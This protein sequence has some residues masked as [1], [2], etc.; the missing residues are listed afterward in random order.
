VSDPFTLTPDQVVTVEPVALSL[1]Q[2][3]SVEPITPAPAQ[4]FT[5]QEASKPRGLLQPGNIDLAAQ[6][7]VF[8]DGQVSTVASRSFRDDQGREVLIPTVAADGSRMLSDKEAWEQYRRTGKHLGMFESP[9]TADIYAE[10]L[11]N[12]YAA[13]KYG[14]LQPQPRFTA[15]A[16]GDFVQPDPRSFMVSPGQMTADA[17]ASGLSL[18]PE[19]AQ[20]LAEAIEDARKQEPVEGERVV[21]KTP[22]AG[23]IYGAHQSWIAMRG[24]KN[25]AAGRGENEDYAALAQ[26]IVKRERDAQR[27]AE[28]GTLGRI[29]DLATSVPGYAAEFIATGGAFT[30]GKG[31]VQRAALKLLEKQ[32]EQTAVRVGVKVAGGAAGAALQTAAVGSQRIAQ[33]AVENMAPKLGLTQDEAGRLQLILL[34]EGDGFAEAVGK[35]YW[36][37][38]IQTASERTGGIIGKLLGKIPGA[39]KLTG[40]KAAIVSQW[41]SKP[42]NTVGKLATLASKAQWHGVLPEVGEELVAEAAEV[43]TGLKDEWQIGP[44]QTLEMAAAFSLFP[45]AGA[46]VRATGKALNLM[47]TNPEAAQALAQGAEASRA[48]VPGVESREE[49]EAVADAVKALAEEQASTAQEPAPHAQPQ[50]I[51][52][53]SPP[54]PEAASAQTPSA[55]PAG[56]QVTAP[57]L[58]VAESAPNLS[59]M[60]LPDL[61]KMA[62][63]L[64]VKGYS[65]KTKAAVIGMIEERNRRQPPTQP[66][67]TTDTSPPARPDLANPLVAPEAR[68]LVDRV[69]A[70]RTAAGKPERRADVAVFQAAT[71]RAQADPEGVR[72]QLLNAADQGTVMADVDTVAA[73]QVLDRD[74]LTALQSGD[75]AALQQAIDLNDAYRRTGTEAGRAFRQRRDW[76]ETPE[77]RFARTLADAILTPPQK[78][79]KKIDKARA[80]GNGE[81]VKQAQREWADRVQGL[82]DQLAKDGIDLGDVQGLAQDRVKGMRALRAIQAYKADTW[83][84]LYE[85][86]RNAI[87]SAPTTHAANLIGNFGH[88]TWHFAAERLAEATA[89]TFAQRPTGA[90][91]GEFKYM[92]QGMLP[93]LSQGARNFLLSWKTETPYFEQSLGR[94]GTRKIEESGVAIGGTKGRIV[95]MFGDRLLV[96]SD[97]LAKT[98]FAQMDVGTR[99]YRIA[100][101]EGLTGEAL[102]RRI[103]E[104]V[105][106]TN[107]EAW[108]QAIATARELTFQQQLGKAG[109]TALHIR[110][111]VPGSRYVLPFITTLANIFKLGVQKSPLGIFKLLKSFY[112]ADRSGDWSSVTPLMAQQMIAWGIMLALLSNDPDD[113]WIT[114]AADELQK[115][116]RELA[117]RAFPTQSVKI[118]GRWYSYSRVEPF[119]TALALAVDI[120]DGLR[121]RKGVRA[122]TTPLYSLIG[123]IRSKTFLSGISDIVEAVDSEKPEQA[124]AKWASSF[125]ISWMPNIVRSGARAA[126][127]TFPNRR[128]FGKGNDWWAG[129]G[130]R[131]IERLEVTAPMLSTPSYDLWGRPALRPG[132]PVP[133]T[134][135]VWRLMVP[136]AAKPEDVFIGD[137]IL[138]AWNRE[139]PDDEK[140][141]ALPSPVYTIGGKKHYMTDEQYGQFVRL[142]GQLAKISLERVLAAPE[143]AEFAAGASKPTEAH[144]KLLERIID[145]SRDRA[146]EALTR[147]WLTNE[148]LD[149]EAVL[150]QVQSP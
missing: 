86:W 89:N 45:M 129:L 9:E 64:G 93:G 109:R 83:D 72:R 126:Q 131:T 123:Q 124:I 52:D 32:A 130:K 68:N 117:R 150:Q 44:Q 31:M 77:Q 4:R 19:S 61:R 111:E 53:M 87:L 125:A 146:R 102:S 80:S 97:E 39:A 115:G 108:T 22:F 15:Q 1:D 94:E 79:A 133:G 46:A 67:T 63:S 91:W 96:A 10:Q 140:Y 99:A 17:R 62:Q 16:A 141:P 121:G 25:I 122:I 92:L 29:V 148:P 100:K 78:M 105:I 134:D 54:Q 57:E 30:V 2:V 40:L 84:K 7:R 41:L 120:T 21:E 98:L 101:A 128:V 33:N 69:D 106:D 113:P 42:G 60:T 142:S 66:P 74:A 6:P 50:Q 48:N 85:F 70:A 149:V 56:V 51:H 36:K 110:R 43:G 12:E 26:L 13:G 138:M 112:K 24:A 90:Q 65:G 27:Q 35:G 88:A 76:V 81:Q 114:G 82:K 38:Y 145:R 8:H 49:R 103:H 135:V 127:D 58:Q 107:S 71:E 116:P 37:E 136:I 143:Y 18:S 139:H 23:G 118:G 137:R 34:D 144:I 104:Q 95:R 28:M 59:D 73:R 20:K 119:A 47:Q 11:H 132:S 14:S 5:A 55:T 147:S 75:P 3:A